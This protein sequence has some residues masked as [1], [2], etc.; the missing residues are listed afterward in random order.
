MTH[1]ELV[2]VFYPT[3]MS[4]FRLEGVARIRTSRA[5]AMEMGCSVY[6]AEWLLWHEAIA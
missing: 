5:V 4:W 6:G 2:P 3:E 1:P